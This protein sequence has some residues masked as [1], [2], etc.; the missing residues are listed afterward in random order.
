VAELKT[1]AVRT[2][3]GHE[4]AALRH[5][6]LGELVCEFGRNRRALDK[7][8][9]DQVPAQE[10]VEDPLNRL[11]MLH[12]APYDIRPLHHLCQGASYD[13]MADCGTVLLGPGRGPV[14]EDERLFELALGHEVF[15]H[16][17]EFL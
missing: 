8:L 9:P 10:F 16:G 14:V 13:R 2:W 7:K 12:A 3:H 6:E 11:L 15:G 5:H 4:L 1:K 17:L